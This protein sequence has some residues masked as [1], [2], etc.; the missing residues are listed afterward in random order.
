MGADFEIDPVFVEATDEAGLSVASANVRCLRSEGGCS[1]ETGRLRACVASVTALFSLAL[2][3]MQPWV[4]K[5][6]TSKEA[7]DSL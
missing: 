1:T 7:I 5:S 4:R 6:S 3:I 2:G